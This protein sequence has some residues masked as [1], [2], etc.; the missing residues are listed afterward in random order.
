MYIHTYTHTGNK[1]IPAAQACMC[2]IWRDLRAKGLTIPA[3]IC[4][5]LLCRSFAAVT[6]ESKSIGACQP[7]SFWPSLVCSEV[8]AILMQD[9]LF[10]GVCVSGYVCMYIYIYIYI[11][12]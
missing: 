2:D 10:T 7:D 5:E 11:Y 12:I 1:G 9:M 4:K 3:E 8:E 6:A